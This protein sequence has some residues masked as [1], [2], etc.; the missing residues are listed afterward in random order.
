MTAKDIFTEHQAGRR[1]I[2]IKI[3]TPAGTALGR[4]GRRYNVAKRYI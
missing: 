3:F 2:L 4:D 1:Y